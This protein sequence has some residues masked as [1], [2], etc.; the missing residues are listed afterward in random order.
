MN[1]SFSDISLFGK[2]IFFAFFFLNIL[3]II[4]DIRSRIIPNIF[5]IFLLALIPFWYSV[6][7]YESVDTIYKLI[8][9]SFFVLG[10]GILFFDKKTAL[11]S[12][13]IKYGAILILFLWSTPLSFFIGNIGVMTIILLLFWWSMILGDVSFILTQKGLAFFREKYSTIRIKFAQQYSNFQKLRNMG[14]GIGIFIFDWL[15]IGFFLSQLIPQIFLIFS[16]FHITSSGSNEGDFYFLLSLFIFFLRPF[17]KSWIRSSTNIFIVSTVTLCIFFAFFLHYWVS[18]MF[19]IILNYIENIWKFAIFM[20][21]LWWITSSTFHFHR[22]LYGQRYTEFT[23]PYSVLIF[24]AFVLSALFP[25]DF[26]WFF[27]FWR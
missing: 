16:S 10:V 18:V 21:L 11:W 14:M 7:S 15:V 13:D 12:G 8:I 4:S 5:L 24:L 2:S 20:I 27:A 25:F 19:G 17:I 1:I 6:F 22:Y 23:F 3:I 26:L 9:L